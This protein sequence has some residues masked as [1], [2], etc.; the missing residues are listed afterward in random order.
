MLRD[1]LGRR[2]GREIEVAVL[3]GDRGAED[4][5][6]N[7][8]TNEEQSVSGGTDIMRSAAPITCANTG[9]LTSPP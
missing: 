9:A 8:P 6:T 4:E 1:H 2:V 5:V 7:D 3:G